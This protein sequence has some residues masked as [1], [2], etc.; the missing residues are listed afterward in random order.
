MVNIGYETVNE[1]KSKAVLQ[2]SLNHNK[3]Q[4]SFTCYV[5]EESKE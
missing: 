4:W 1:N 2:I 5:T 3:M